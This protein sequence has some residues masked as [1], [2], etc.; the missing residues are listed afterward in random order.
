[1]ILCR[2]HEALRNMA[3]TDSHQACTGLGKNNQKLCHRPRMSW[4]GSVWG[5]A[6]GAKW[7][8]FEQNQLGKKSAVAIAYVKFSPTLCKSTPRLMFAKV[9]KLRM[10]SEP[11]R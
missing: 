11:T 4:H 3:A 1:M 10:T 5:L 8:H 2:D 9:I 6:D 7:T